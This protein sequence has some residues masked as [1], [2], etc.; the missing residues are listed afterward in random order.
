[1]APGHSSEP[2][3]VDGSPAFKKMAAL[4]LSISGAHV[5]HIGV[6]YVDLRRPNF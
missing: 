3:H 6:F 2:G 5:A 4:E 1:M